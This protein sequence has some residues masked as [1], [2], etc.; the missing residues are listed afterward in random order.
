MS[1]AMAIEVLDI[2]SANNSN[3]IELLVTRSPDVAIHAWKIEDGTSPEHL[4]DIL[5]IV[6]QEALTRVV[7]MTSHLVANRILQQASV[8]CNDAT[9]QIAHRLLERKVN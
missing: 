7:V 6:R 5:S 2:V 3:L 8:T 1:A 4:R 9:S